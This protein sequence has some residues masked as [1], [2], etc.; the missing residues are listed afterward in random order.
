MPSIN[1]TYLP[2]FIALDVPSPSIKF[3]TV[4]ATVSGFVIVITKGSVVVPVPVK[5]VPA[6]PV[7][8]TNFIYLLSAIVASSS[9]SSLTLNVVSLFVLVSAAKSTQLDQSLS[10]AV[11]S[12][13][14]LYLCQT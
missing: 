6:V 3:H 13:S 1:L 8:E 2:S 7:A 12:K 14:Y 4:L 5:L 11:P 10:C 9:S